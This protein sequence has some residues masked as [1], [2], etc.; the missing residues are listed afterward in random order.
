[1]VSVADVGLTATAATGDAATVMAPTPLFRSTAA[2]MIAFPGERA[3]TAPVA[4]TVATLGRLELQA[5]DL[6]DSTLPCA[7]SG[8]TLSWAVWPTVRSRL[9]GDTRT[10][11][12]GTG[13]TSTCATAD[14]PSTLA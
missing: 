3:V 8:S 1:M 7:S 6:P 14:F 5:T 10:A 2:V 12:T 9:D 4:L 13:T 11:T